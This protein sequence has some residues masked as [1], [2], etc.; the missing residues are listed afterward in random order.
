M[1]KTSAKRHTDPN[2]IVVLA[3][4]QKA[5]QD[6]L[7]NDP[8]L[9]QSSIRAL[10]KRT[11]TRSIGEKR[12]LETHLRILTGLERLVPSLVHTLSLPTLLSLAY[13]PVSKEGHWVEFLKLQWHVLQRYFDGL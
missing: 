5:G 4:L 7:P 12:F 8:S 9:L 6:L 2:T 1:P 3:A 10:L 13:A 11:E